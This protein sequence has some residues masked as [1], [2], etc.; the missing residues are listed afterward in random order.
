MKRSIISIAMFLMIVSSKNS[1]A[2]SSGDIA[3]NI[4]GLT[5]S[6]SSEPD[7]KTHEARE[8]EI[9]VR[10][11]RDFRR[12]YKNVP[13][14]KWFNSESGPFAS[15]NSNGT[16]TKIVYDNKGR[17]AYSINSYT[18]SNLDRKVRTLVK[19]TYYDQDIIGVHQFEFDNKTVYVIKMLDQQSNPLTLKVCD[20][21]IED[22]TTHV[23]SK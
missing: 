14:V 10:A 15:F 9:N 23:K 7:M 3:L 6:L 16:H 17:R 5:T 18:E 13:D 12:A 21:R 4:P 20:G 11:M 8:T 19:S 2:Q 1:S 22:I